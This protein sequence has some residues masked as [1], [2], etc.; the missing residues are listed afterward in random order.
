[1]RIKEHQ[2]LTTRLPRSHQPRF[3]KTNPFRRAQDTR[4]NLQLGHVIV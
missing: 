3:D 4:W 1:V 2:Y